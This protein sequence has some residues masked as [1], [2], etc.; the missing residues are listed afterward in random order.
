[1]NDEGTIVL[2]NTDMTD[3]VPWYGEKPD[4]N[5]ELSW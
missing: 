3:A 2:E 1:L 5:G 4:K